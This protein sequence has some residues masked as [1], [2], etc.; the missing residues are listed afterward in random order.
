MSIRHLISIAAVSLFCSGTIT[1]A[2]EVGRLPRL[3]PEPG[4]TA[5]VEKHGGDYV[6]VQP[7]GSNLSLLR[8]AD[9]ESGSETPLFEEE[10]Y[11]YDGHKDLSVAVTAGSVDVKYQLYLYNPGSKSYADFAVPSDVAERQNCNGFWS[12][13]RTTKEKGIISSCKNDGRWVHDVIHIGPDGAAWISEQTRVVY[14][15]RIEW[16]YFGK[17]VLTVT[18]DRQGKV[19]SE[20]VASQEETGEPAEWEVP[21]AKLPLYAAPDPAARTKAYLIKGDQTRMLEFKGDWMKI[22]YSGK[23]DTIERWVSLR[24]AYDLAARYVPGRAHP[25]G[26]TLKALNYDGMEKDADYFRNLFTLMMGNSGEQDITITQGELHLIFTGTDGK[27]VTH[28]LYDL[29]E[30]TLTPGSFQTLDDNAVEKHGDRY[31]LFH[32]TTEEETYV[33]FFPDGLAP[34]RYS[35]RAVITDPNLPEPVFAEWGNDMDF[36]PRLPASLI[37]P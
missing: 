19:I 31:V 30:F 22:A 2:D 15:E 13:E 5:R 10:D 20:K 27:S 4:I 8:E 18:Y 36:P 11:D 9:M 33:P 28:K 1:L 14:D 29:H 21:V 24:E 3:T 23:K 35:V 12:I 32:A 26:L 17:P 7:N 6:L 16:P 25:A 34:G 37:K